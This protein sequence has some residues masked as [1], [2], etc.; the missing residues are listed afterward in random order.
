MKPENTIARSSDTAAFLHSLLWVAESDD[1]PHIANWTIHQFHPEFTAALESFLDGFRE[2]IAARNPEINPDDCDRS[3]GGNVF[4]SLS[5]HGCGFWDERDSEL[6]DALQALLVE[7]SG[8][9]Y[10]FEELESNLA[11]FDGRIHLA[12]STAAYRREYLAKLFTTDWTLAEAGRLYDE[13][14]GNIATA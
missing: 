11:K 13:R 7:Y 4:F 1:A 8:G 3:F 9:K 14:N 6:G 12:Y 5:R 2:F 10:S